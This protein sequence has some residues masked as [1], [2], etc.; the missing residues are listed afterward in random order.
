LSFSPWTA[1]LITVIVAV[2]EVTGYSLVGAAVTKIEV[3]FVTDTML[4]DFTSIKVTLLVIELATTV[5]NHQETV[6]HTTA[7][8]FEESSSSSS[9][10]KVKTQ[11]CFAHP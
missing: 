11:G 7:F 6:T 1:F 5:R 9:N 8:N 3:G 10:I 4:V 2:L